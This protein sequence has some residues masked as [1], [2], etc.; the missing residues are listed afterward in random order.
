M[1]AAT[2][3]FGRS[4]LLDDGD[5]VFAGGGLREV[6]GLPNLVQALT[7][8]VLTPFGSD[9]FNTGYGLDIAAAFT[10]PNTVSGVKQL[11]QLN[12]VRTLGADP[13]VRDIRRVV[14]D[15][16]PDL[17]A[18]DPAQAA[19]AG[20]ARTRRT[21]TARVDV[22]TVAGDPLALTLDVGV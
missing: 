8:R 5:L 22:D 16:D 9:P 10:L 1:S 17:T 3:A 21:L 14:F 7:A 20:L 2:A 13:R 12:L 4:L 18:A 15:D 19:A 6:E 11:V